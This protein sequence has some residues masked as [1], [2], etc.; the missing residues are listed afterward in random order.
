MLIKE[1]EGEEGKSTI[2]YI[3]QTTRE[4]QSYV[5]SDLMGVTD[6]YVKRFKELESFLVESY[7]Q[8]WELRMRPSDY[9]SIQKAKLELG[10]PLR[11][12]RS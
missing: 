10:Q 3:N 4:L 6:F 1:T 12:E 9:F 2:T 5:M 7:R 11:A 8:S